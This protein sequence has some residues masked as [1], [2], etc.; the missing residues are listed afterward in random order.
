MSTRSNTPVGIALLVFGGVAV[1]AGWIA[2]S[3]LGYLEATAVGSEQLGWWVPLL[4]IGLPVLAL[5]GIALYL[6]LS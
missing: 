5:M 1:V 4:S 2:S 3:L 6:Y